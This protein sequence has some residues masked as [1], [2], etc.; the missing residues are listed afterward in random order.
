ML[1]GLDAWIVKN[2]VILGDLGCAAVTGLQKKVFSKIREREEFR[3]DLD[4]PLLIKFLAAYQEGCVE[5]VLLSMKSDGE[6]EAIPMNKLVQALYQVGQYLSQS[7]AF[8][9]LKRVGGDPESAAVDRKTFSK[10]VSVD[11]SDRA[12]AWRE[13]CGFT[14]AQLEVIQY[15]FD[16]NR[17]SEKSWLL[18][19][20][21]IDCG[22]GVLEALKLLDLAPTTL[23]KREML[24]CSLARVDRTGEGKINFQDFLSLV[25]HLE[26]QKIYATSREESEMA[27]VAG[28]DADAVRQFRQ[29]FNDCGPNESGKVAIPKIQQLFT[30]LGL[31]EYPHQRQLLN[32]V[33]DLV[34]NDNS[35]LAF[36]GF[37][38]LLHRFE[39]AL[40]APQN[41]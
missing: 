14:D 11:R 5:E 6:E 4:F 16:R 24:L 13:K 33:I 15:A 36:T 19:T 32:A 3:G 10:L 17:D 34:A 12:L 25:R 38:D 2:N 1:M 29:V 7:V 21:V 23:D 30:D 22:T 20:D 41:K 35:G 37:L 26:N 9:L 18:G 39:Q 28:M 31:V 27:Q 8:T 40:N